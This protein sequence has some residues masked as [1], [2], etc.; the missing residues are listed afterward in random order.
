MIFNIVESFHNKSFFYLGCKEFW[1]VQSSFP[2]ITKLS[3]INVKKKAESISSFEF[4]TLYTTTPHKLLQK[5]I[6]TVI[7]LKSGNA[8]AFLKRIS[9]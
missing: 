8:L 1:V 5:V 4:S 9:I 7:N 2:N 3:K 6:S